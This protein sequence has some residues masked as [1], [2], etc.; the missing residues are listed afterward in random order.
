MPASTAMVRRSIGVRRWTV[1]LALAAAGASCA[2]VLGLEDPAGRLGGEGG[3]TGGTPTSSGIGAGNPGTGPG[4]E[5]GAGATSSTGAGGG[6]TSSTGAGGGSTSSTGGGGGGPTGGG[7]LELPP[8]FAIQ[9]LGRSPAGAVAMVKRDV[10]GTGSLCGDTVVIDRL[11][12]VAIGTSS[13]S[14]LGQIEGPASLQAV[15]VEQVGDWVGVTGVT[16]AG[17]VTLH[18]TPPIPPVSPARTA[19]FFG[20]WHVAGAGQ[21]QL[22]ASVAQIT[23]GATLPTDTG[24]AHLLYGSVQRGFSPDLGGVCAVMAG[25]GIELHFASISPAAVC[26]RPRDPVQDSHLDA[27]QAVGPWALV[28][29]DTGSC[30]VVSVDDVADDRVV[31][32]CGVVSHLLV[33][34]EEGED[35]SFVGMAASGSCEGAPGIVQSTA[36]GPDTTWCDAGAEP[37]VRLIPFRVDATHLHFLRATTSQAAFWRVPREGGDAVMTA[38]LCTECIV[39]DV[40]AAAGAAYVTGAAI[41]PIEVSGQAIGAGRSFWAWVALADL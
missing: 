12:A 5:G 3:A 21:G 35:R 7:A 33:Q 40:V 10:T 19:G 6:S 27:G 4:G 29:D 24:G 26:T 13:C 16:L 37:D 18:A 14:I 8:E 11:A 30:A 17:T 38:E 20:W 31:G 32:G 28:R 25:D 15:S 34:D 36:G 9:V 41:A 39:T 23:A 2:D 1:G 22:L